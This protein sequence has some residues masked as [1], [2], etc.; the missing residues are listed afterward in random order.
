VYF[1]R[2]SL[3]SRIF[4]EYD[5]TFPLPD[6]LDLQKASIEHDRMNGRLCI[7]IPKCK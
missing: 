5:E 7:R 3:Y 1:A 2:H 6:F 4:G